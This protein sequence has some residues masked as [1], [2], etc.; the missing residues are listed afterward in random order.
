MDIEDVL[1]RPQRKEIECLTKGGYSR[2]GAIRR[3]L[4]LGMLVRR[5]PDLETDLIHG[6][7]YILPKSK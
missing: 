6:T 5:V 4:R 1:T 3:L 7:N 2:I